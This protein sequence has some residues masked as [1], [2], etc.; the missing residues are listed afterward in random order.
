M[1]VNEGPATPCQELGMEPC[2]GC[3]VCDRSQRANGSSVV[4]RLLASQPHA[5]AAT[6][7]LQRGRAMQACVWPQRRGVQSNRI[8]VAA[9]S[10]LF[11]A[12]ASLRQNWGQ[13][14]STHSRTLVHLAWD[15]GDGGLLRLLLATS[16][17]ADLSSL[18]VMDAYRLLRKR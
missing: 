5:S 8:N 16:S 9:P 11:T 14:C 3:G 13:L 15:G 6:R 2:V 1:H 12:S 4:H 18:H 7:D 10:S 17:D